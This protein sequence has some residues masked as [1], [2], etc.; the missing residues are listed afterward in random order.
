MAIAAGAG[1]SSS[2]VGSAM[3]PQEGRADADRAVVEVQQRQQEKRKT[4]AENAAD[5]KKNIDSFRNFSNL[6]SVAAGRRQQR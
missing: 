4:R 2:E 3:P 5:R 1:A 6:A